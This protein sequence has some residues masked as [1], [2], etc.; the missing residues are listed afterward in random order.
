MDW[1][2]QGRKKLLSGGTGKL[3]KRGW[4]LSI[5]RRGAKPNV[6]RRGVTATRSLVETGASYV[7]RLGR[8]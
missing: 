7:K 4:S 3:G 8:K 5:G 2:F 6:A 1:R